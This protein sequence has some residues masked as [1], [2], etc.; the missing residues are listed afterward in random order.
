MIAF[1]AMMSSSQHVASEDCSVIPQWLHS[2]ASFQRSAAS[3]SPV[4]VLSDLPDLVDPPSC[5]GTGQ[6]VA[7]TDDGWS[8]EL[9]ADVTCAGVSLLSDYVA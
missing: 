7:S 9:Q 6:Q 2:T 3:W 4:V 5:S 1:T 8:A